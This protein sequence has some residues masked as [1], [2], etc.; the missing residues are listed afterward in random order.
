MVKLIVSGLLGSGLLSGWAAEPSS[1]RSSH[2]IMR[3]TPQQWK[4]MTIAHLQLP[5]FS[6]DP[7]AEKSLPKSLSL[8]SRLAYVPSERDQASCGDCWQWAS[9]GVMEIAND[10]QNGV[11]ERLSVQ[12]LNSCNS[13]Q[14]GC[15]GGNPQMFASFYATKGYAIPWANA[16]GRFVSG[17]GSCASMPCENIATNPRYTL[18]GITPVAINT[19][20]V[21]QAPAIA[22]IKS[23]LNQ[24][25][26]IYFA[27]YLATETAWNQFRSFWNNQSESTV[28][29]QYFPG[30]MPDEGSGSHAVLCVGYNDDNASN[31]YWIMVNSWGT[32]G[33]RPNGIFRVAM[34]QNYDLL[35]RHL[36]AGVH[37]HDLALSAMGRLGGAGRS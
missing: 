20:G 3:M 15:N 1:V 19:S 28:W 7:K 16:N 21:G 27:F 31:R 18:T 11:H 12:F 17:N 13:G 4:E 9:T 33:G 25:K 36:D 5:Q 8:L 10:V 30:Q 32:P 22:N 35:A 2:S 24:N 37:E 26:A 6:A 23:A 14:C 29:T 34:D